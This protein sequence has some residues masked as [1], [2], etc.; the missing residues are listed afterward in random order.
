MDPRFGPPYTYPGFPPNFPLPNLYFPPSVNSSRSHKQST[1]SHPFVHPQAFRTIEDIFEDDGTL[2]LPPG[3]P[4]SGSEAIPG[5]EDLR[6]VGE[7]IRD[8][9]RPRP[10][11]RE[12]H[13]AFL[14]GWAMHGPAW[15]DIASVVVTRTP[16]QVQSHAIKF[17]VFQQ[18]LSGAPAPMPLGTD[19]MASIKNEPD[20]TILASMAAVGSPP[21][22]PMQQPAAP[23]EAKMPSPPEMA[24]QSP[25]SPLY[26]TAKSMM[27]HPQGASATAT[28]RA[29]AAM[30]Y[31]PMMARPFAPEYQFPTGYGE[32][33]KRPA[34][35][36]ARICAILDPALVDVNSINL[37]VNQ[38]SECPL[39]SAI[40]SRFPTS[41][42]HGRPGHV[43]PSMLQA[44]RKPIDGQASA[45]AGGEEDAEGMEEEE[46]PDEDAAGGCADAGAHPTTSPASSP[47]LPP[48]LP[49][50]M[51]G[52]QAPS[53]APAASAAAPMATP[54]ST[55]SPA[56]LMAAASAP[57]AL[58]LPAAA[59][60]GRLATQVPPP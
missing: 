7:L 41:I 36:P 51:G 9:P 21:A 43:F 11:L 19:S 27:P 53:L 42:F 14:R 23:A 3:G 4:S 16:L 17:G 47:V 45:Q 28:P 22:M 8:E 58:G 60:A 6:K 57:A 46:E 33:P 40:L 12:E 48:P 13:K 30:G 56:D 15:K 31:Q 34:H 44:T 1:Q 50:P 2:V 39:T 26:P 25:A 29:P 52:S 5:R 20:T 24:P 49:V 18:R 35:R 54:P 32:P 38:T 37:N 55:P 10:W 59:L